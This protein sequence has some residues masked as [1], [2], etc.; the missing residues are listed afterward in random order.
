[1]LLINLLTKCLNSHSIV[2]SSLSVVSGFGPVMM[3]EYASWIN[4]QSIQKLDAISLKP[5]AV[6]AALASKNRILFGPI[7]TTVLF[8]RRCCP[9]TLMKSRKWQVGLQRRSVDTL[10]NPPVLQT[11]LFASLHTSNNG[12]P[13]FCPAAWARQQVHTKA[14]TA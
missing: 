6:D 8:L 4:S 10:A 9:V 14:S 2:R 7:R 1:M 11:M 12:S 13:L 5:F 3:Q